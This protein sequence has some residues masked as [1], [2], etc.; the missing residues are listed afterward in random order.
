MEGACKRDKT[1]NLGN[2]APLQLSREKNPVRKT[3]T[4][5]GEGL[6][7]KERTRSKAAS[8]SPLSSAVLSHRGADV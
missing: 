5:E 8:L 7:L 6:P 1:S 3:Q 4:P 2:S